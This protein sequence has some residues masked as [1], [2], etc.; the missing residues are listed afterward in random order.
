VDST[1]QGEYR[2]NFFCGTYGPRSD[3]KRISK[4]AVLHGIVLQVSVTSR[5]DAQLEIGDVSEAISVTA[6]CRW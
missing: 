2:L 4:K 5:V 6:K 3:G 1:E